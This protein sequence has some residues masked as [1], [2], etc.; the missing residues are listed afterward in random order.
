MRIIRALR[1]RRWLLGAAAAALILLA[2]GGAVAATA[3]SAGSATPAAKL[4]TTAKP[5][6]DRPAYDWNAP[7]LADGVVVPDLPTAKAR[8]PFTPTVPGNAAAPSRLYVSDPSRSP[9]SEQAF[10]AVV[11]DPKYGLFQVLEQQT[12][13]TEDQLEAWAEICNTCTTQQVATLGPRHYLIL[14]SAG[15]G[16]AISWLT[17]T[18]LHTIIGPDETF[19]EANALALAAATNG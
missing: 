7:P 9:R 5:V 11:R 14:A 17:G 19:T 13:M 16:L 18:T 2:V 12:A 3:F 1:E 15:H 10:A 6:D 8:L 4:D